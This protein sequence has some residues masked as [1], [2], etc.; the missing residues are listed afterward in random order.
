MEKAPP[1]ANKKCEVKKSERKMEADLAKTGQVADAM[2]PSEIVFQSMQWYCYML[3][4]SSNYMITPT[5]Q[6]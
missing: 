6:Y 2:N 5:F 1:V 3:M 4:M